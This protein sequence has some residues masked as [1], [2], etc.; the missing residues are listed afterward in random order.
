MRPARRDGDGAWGA[1]AETWGGP[2]GTE[3][4]G[5][6]VTGVLGRLAG[7]A[8]AGLGPRERLAAAGSG[9]GGAS[10]LPPPPPPSRAGGVGAAR[11]RLEE[12]PP[13]PAPGGVAPP[14][15]SRGP[16]SLVLGRPRCQALAL[17]VNRLILPNH[18]L[19][20]ISR[21]R[22]WVMVGLI[23]LLF[24]RYTGGNRAQRG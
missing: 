13:P 9:R 1:E 18:V 14:A 17:P 24:T 8:L 7:G 15:A 6:L 3:A 5:A 22:V 20:I 23:S 10:S 11:L 2:R 21:V 4:R 16:G 12:P 19:H